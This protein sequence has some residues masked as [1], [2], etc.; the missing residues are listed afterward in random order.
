MF[1]LVEKKQNLLNLVNRISAPRYL[2]L[3][4]DS[5]DPDAHLRTGGPEQTANRWEFLLARAYTSSCHE[6]DAIQDT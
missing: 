1:A 6:T 2:G 5:Q 4:S 3:R